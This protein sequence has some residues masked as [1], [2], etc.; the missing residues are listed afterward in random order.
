[1]ENGRPRGAMLRL[2]ILA[3]ALATALIHIVLAIPSNLVMFYLNGLGYIALAAALF[4]PQLQP[5]GRLVRYALLALTAVTIVGWAIV[6]E[7]SALA[8][9]DKL[10]E[11]AL[12][13]LLVVEMRASGTRGAGVAR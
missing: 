13:A 8:Y 10:I 7:R 11:L 4:V 3:L 5:Y 9:V 2:G 1:M 12:I 6:G